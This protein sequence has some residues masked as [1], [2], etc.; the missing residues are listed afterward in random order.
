MGSKNRIK[1]GIII[2]FILH[3]HRNFYNKT[4]IYMSK[5]IQDKIKEKH[6]DVIKYCEY[7]NFQKLM[8]N[9]IA[10]CK[11][12]KCDNTINYIS[13]IENTFILYALKREK[14]HTSCNTIYKLKP[15]TLKK[16]YK[17]ESFKLFKKECK[18]NIEEYLAN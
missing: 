1:L 9:T 12:E 10:T 13:Y 17:D 11:Y 18:E 8:D 16:Y 14:H 7:E 2:I 4:N 3:F 5:R 6:Y 15:R